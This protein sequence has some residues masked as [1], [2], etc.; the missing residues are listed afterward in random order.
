M[1]A[2]FCKGIYEHTWKKYLGYAVGMGLFFVAAYIL[3]TPKSWGDILQNL[4]STIKTF[5]NYTTWDGRVFYMG[6][7]IRGRELPWHYL[8]VWI[9]ITTP[10]LYLLFMIGGFW[11]TAVHTWRSMSGKSDAVENCHRMFVSLAVVIP[12]AYVVVLRPTLYNG[13]RHFYFTYPL[14]V[15][16]GVLY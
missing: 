2:I 14:L 5:S 6:G 3:M 10:F 4:W 12:F 11:R 8:F 9:G 1:I 13:W 7:W 15:V 16:Q